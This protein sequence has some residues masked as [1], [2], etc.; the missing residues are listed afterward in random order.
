[1]RPPLGVVLGAGFGLVAGTAVAAVTV[2]V[3]FLARQ[4]RGRKLSGGVVLAMGL[5]LTALLALVAG[6]LAPGF[7]LPAFGGQ[8]S[9]VPFAL[10]S[11]LAA[12][13]PFLVVFGTITAVLGV[14]GHGLGDRIAGDVP[15]ADDSRTRGWRVLSP[16][17]V[18]SADERGRVSID[19][20]GAPAG[21]NSGPALPTATWDAIESRTWQLPADLPIET[22]EERLAARI[23]TT[24]GVD[25]ESVSI[26]EHGR[27]SV[28]ASPASRALATE[29]ADGE[30]AVTVETLVPAELEPDDRVTL[31]LGEQSVDGRVLAVTADR[32]WPGGQSRRDRPTDRA[33][34]VSRQHETVPRT[35]ASDRPNAGEACHVTVAVEA[36]AVSP[37]L[38]ATAVALLVKPAGGNHARGA[39]RQLRRR[40][41]ALR[42][43]T[44]DDGEHASLSEHADALTTLAVRP[45]GA[46]GDADGWQ[47]RPPEQATPPG[48]RLDPSDRPDITAEPSG[49]T[50]DE[51]DG[52]VD[53][54]GTGDPLS[55]GTELFVIGP[56]RIVT[57]LAD[58]GIRSSRTEGR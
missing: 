14:Y 52:A 10:A 28:L 15:A 7:E 4:C 35:A 27:A 21:G 17:T 29:L 36:G 31:A 13:A 22:L 5:F 11:I 58:P 18:A 9:R 16:A 25:V 38:T 2:G 43:V 57:R 53:L 40:N 20:T 33:D 30:R 56:A 32:N 3:E 45:P 49:G 37:V 50:A 48:S 34:S 41:L 54:T 1:M 26:D 6:V 42:R 46:S 47:L 8:P 19:V 23:R 55:P 12:D 39:F 51:R 44:I 24:F